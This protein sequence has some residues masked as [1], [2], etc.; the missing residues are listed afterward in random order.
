[1]CIKIYLW[2]LEVSIENN[3]KFATNTIIIY[4]NEYI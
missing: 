3:R 4:Q 1:M 2:I